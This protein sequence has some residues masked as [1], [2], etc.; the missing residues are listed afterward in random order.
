MTHNCHLWYKL[1][2]IK[3]KKVGV[4]IKKEITKKQKLKEKLAY[5]LFLNFELKLI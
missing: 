2:S 3:L 4:Q 1:L 5:Q